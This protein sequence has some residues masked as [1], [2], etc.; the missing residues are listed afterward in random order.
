V[1]VCVCV[2]GGEAQLERVPVVVRPL[3]S[4]KRSPL[5]KIRN[6]QKEQKYGNGSLRD[7]KT[8]LIV[9]AKA[10]I[11]LPYRPDKKVLNLTAVK[12][13]T[14]H[15]SNCRFGAAKLIKAQSAAEACI[16]I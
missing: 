14:V 11:N 1:C 12:A 5:F 7:T 13:K 10:R 2:C 3:P 8:R 6:S 9:L 16:D 15:L 4:S